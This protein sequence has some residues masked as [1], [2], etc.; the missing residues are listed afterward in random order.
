MVWLCLTTS[1][2]LLDGLSF[3]ICLG[4]HASSPPRTLCAIPAQTTSH[5][6]RYTTPT[7]YV[8]LPFFNLW[9]HPWF[10]YP[11]TVM[12]MTVAVYYQSILIDD[13]PKMNH[14]NFHIHISPLLLRVCIQG[15]WWWWDC[16]GA[17]TLPPHCSLQ[18]RTTDVSWRC[19]NKPWALHNLW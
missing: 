3:K 2:A 4:E 8:C 14:L 7:L 10:P 17:G 12:Y 9:I 15:E 18:E 13:L 6:A 16:G 11:S 19:G 5:Y 1:E